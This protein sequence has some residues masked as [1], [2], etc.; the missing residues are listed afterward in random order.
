MREVGGG[1]CTWIFINGGIFERVGV[2]WFKVYGDLDEVFVWELL[3]DG[4][5]FMVFGVLLV[6][7]FKSFMILMVYVNVCMIQ[8]G[9]VLWFGGGMDL[10]LYY[11]VEEDVEY[12]HCV[13]K[14]M[15]NGFDVVWY[16][17]FKEWCDGYFYLFY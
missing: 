4:N 17:W 15:C 3:G 2:N 10:M 5:Y 8:K 1:G 12:F 9:N 7:Y 16:F 14:D 6:L 11:L 13:L